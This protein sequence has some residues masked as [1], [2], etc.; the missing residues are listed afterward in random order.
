[1]KATSSLCLFYH[2]DSIKVS[3][4]LHLK[5]AVAVFSG[6]STSSDKAG[7]GGRLVTQTLTYKGGPVPKKFFFSP[8]GLGR[9]GST[10]IPSLSLV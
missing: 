8:W 5:V 3:P 7:W 4:S 9:G 1:M 10:G 2:V 6:G